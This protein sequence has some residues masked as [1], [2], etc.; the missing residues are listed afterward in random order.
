MV[1]AVTFRTTELVERPIFGVALFRSDNTYIHGPNT[2][3]D[4]VLDQDYHGVYTFYIRW[5]SLPLLAG[6]YRLSIAVFD[7]N[8]LKPHIWHNQL[9]DIE[10]TASIEDHGLVLLNHDWGMI[11]H[12][13]EE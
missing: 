8:H 5:K 11:T 4:Q 10:I 6:E 2:R 3:F 12:Y 9:Y 7:K 13:E 1:V